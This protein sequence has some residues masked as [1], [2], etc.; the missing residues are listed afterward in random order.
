MD[1]FLSRPS[2]RLATNGAIFLGRGKT[3]V[4][5]NDVQTMVNP[6]VFQGHDDPVEPEETRE[7]YHRFRGFCVAIVCIA[8]GFFIGRESVRMNWLESDI[9]QPPKP[10]PR[11]IVITPDHVD[12]L[13]NGNIFNIPRKKARKLPSAPRVPVEEVPP[14]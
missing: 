10:I 12:P 6:N 7:T 4:E 13:P 2:G 14:F 8:L 5:F 11:V 3:M 9:V 1:L